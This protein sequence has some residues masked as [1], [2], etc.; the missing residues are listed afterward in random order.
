MKRKLDP[1]FSDPFTTKRPKTSC[2]LSD[3]PNE[4]LRE[5]F[6]SLPPSDRLNARMVSQFWMQFANEYFPK[7]NTIWLNASMNFSP[8][9]RLFKTFEARLTTTKDKRSFPNLVIVELPEGKKFDEMLN[10][11]KLIGDEIRFLKI[12]TCPNIDQINQQLYGCFPNIEILEVSNENL[13]GDF[14]FPSKLKSIKVYSE[15]TKYH[16]LP[17][18]QSVKSFITKSQIVTY[19]TE[20]LVPIVEPQMKILLDS[21]F[22]NNKAHFELKSSHNFCGEAKWS[23]K[24]VTEIELCQYTFNLAPLTEFN[25]LKKLNLHTRNEDAFVEFTSTNKFIKFSG[26]THLTISG[27]SMQDLKFTNIDKLFQMFPNLECLNILNGSC[28]LNDDDF[29]SI[30]EHMPKL[31]TLRYHTVPSQIS[32]TTLFDS[33][34]F[35]LKDLKHLECLLIQTKPECFAYPCYFEYPVLPKL[36]ILYLKGDGIRY[37]D[38]HFYAQVAQKSPKLRDIGICPR[39]FEQNPSKFYPLLDL[40]HLKDLTLPGECGWMGQAHN[41]EL[42]E[43]VIERCKNLESFYICDGYGFSLAQELYLM[44]KLPKIEILGSALFDGCVFREF[45]REHQTKYLMNHLG[46]DITF[47]KDVNGTLDYLYYYYIPHSYRMKMETALS[48]KIGWN[49]SFRQLQTLII[50]LSNYIN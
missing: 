33:D 38:E 27:C 44:K 4:M 22:T 49:F 48:F 28:I 21:L 24:E 29:R 8:T 12:C 3:L 42:I 5:I 32:L 41:T 17:T 35:S 6:K 30:C 36:K 11:L 7:D 25:S 43:N 14:S 2:E 18:L 13:L 37:L 31:K 40:P 34:S 46:L 23:A 16:K 39:D 9:G 50:V 10:F 26:I 45:F 19:Y 47:Y 20:Y 15:F 1:T